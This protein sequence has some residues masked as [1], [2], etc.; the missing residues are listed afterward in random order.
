MDNKFYITVDEVDHLVHPH[1]KELKKEFKKES[2]QI[3]FRE[4]L[5]GT[6]TLWADDYEL[7]KNA[8]LESTILFKVVKDESIIASASFNKSDCKFDHFRKSVE[9]VM[10]YNDKY[11]KILDAY[12]NTY[13]LI[14][15]TPAMTPLTLTKRSIV[16]I[17]IQGE[18]VA[19]SYSGGTYWETE[20]DDPVDDEA[21]LTNKYHFSKGPKYIEV[22][23]EGFNYDINTAFRGVESSDCWN[24]VCI[25]VVNGVKYKIPCSIKFTKVANANE[26]VP[27]ES[28]AIYLLSTGSGDGTR[29]VG[30]EEV[31]EYLYRYDTYRIEV[32]TDK[33]GTGNKIYQS[34]ALYGKDSGFTLTSGENLY[35]MNKV[36]Q[37]QPLAKV[38]TPESFYLGQFIVEYQI[39]GRLLCDTDVTQSGTVLYDLPYD[40]FITPRK[41]YKK[42]IGLQGFDSES[43]VV[44]IYQTQ[45]T[46]EEPTAYGLNDFGEYF[47]APY[48]IYGQYFYP[49]AK[50]SWANTS[51]WVM[52]D[53]RFASSGFGF[54]AWNSQFYK[55]Y[56]LKNSYHI[57]DVIKAILAKIDP[58]ITH[59]KTSA[60][61]EFLY[62]HTG[63]TASELGGCDIYITQKTNVLKGEYDQAAQKAEIKLK[64]ITEMLRDCFRCYWYIDDENRFRIEHIS[65]FTHGL[66]Y[67][68]PSD[69]LDLTDEYDK[70]NKKKILYCQQSIKYEKEDLSARYELSWADDVTDSMGNINVDVNN[71]YIKKDKKSEIHID[72][73]TSD[74]DYMLFLPDNF[75]EDGFALL[76]A[77]SQKKVPIVHEEIKSEIQNN[78]IYDIYPQNWYASFNQLI[79]HYMEDMP[80][81]N[82]SCNNIPYL[83]V[84]D[85][86]SCVNHTI[87]FPSGSVEFNAYTVITTE[88][89]S[90]YIE[91]I[92]LD[93]DT[94]LTTVDV[95]YKPV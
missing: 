11:T 36:D 45:D 63:A 68:S 25:K 54:E 24:A 52:L 21:A 12:E 94:N 79:Q 89:G 56:T 2:N 51:M 20:V 39:W 86:K 1:Y 29:N 84:E 4:S 74:I 35:R 27:D 40:D 73:F 58:S 59:E 67:G 95:R 44:K 28:P 66:S 23:L 72:G 81:Y 31:P 61:S 78:R 49:L 60:Y 13:D 82:V 7:I 46:S 38:P 10:S 33:D 83:A 5:N 22:D 17:Y 32:Y 3:F 80:G 75:S 57:A 19:S 42:C 64:Q 50:S 30:T 14:K 65:Y 76:M 47:K 34:V 16:Q 8:S 87:E 48:S 62:G 91:S 71:N 88:L 43:S 90:G 18:K 15:L 9:L 93:I 26:S 55:E 92:S 37:A 41:N 77:D 6:I 70:F 69:Q 85:I 53:E